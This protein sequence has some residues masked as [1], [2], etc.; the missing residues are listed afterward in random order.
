MGRLILRS[1]RISAYNGS[2]VRS[3]VTR[4]VMDSSEFTAAQAVPSTL[5]IWGG[6]VT[7]TGKWL[8]HAQMAVPGPVPP[9]S[10]RR[11]A[12]TRVMS[13]L[14]LNPRPRPHHE[15]SPSRVPAE[16]AARTSSLE[17]PLFLT[18]VLGYTD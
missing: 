1:I 10:L 14:G 8:R 5:R 7:A 3:G 15:V 18:P 17:L 9:P 12:G 4:W 6:R 11:A 2:K 13:P 16:G